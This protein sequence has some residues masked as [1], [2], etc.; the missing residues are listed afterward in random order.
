M[1]TRNLHYR[2]FAAAILFGALLSPAMAGDGKACCPKCKTF[3]E[4]KVE[5]GTEEKHCW[6]VKPKAICIPRVTFSWQWPW[7]KK[8]IPAQCDGNC[9]GGCSK[10]CCA[11]PKL[12]RTR[13]VCTLEKH[14]YE[15]PTCKYK[16]VPKEAKNCASIDPEELEKTAA[17][18]MQ[19]QVIRR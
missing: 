11:P 6:K 15:C 1:S 14:T 16:W 10:P 4:L 19:T 18:V 7:D 17:S 2:L 9:D 3:C 13:T 12:A 8:K 5:E